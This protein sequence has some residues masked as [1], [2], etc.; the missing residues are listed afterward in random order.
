MASHNHL[1]DG[2]QMNEKRGMRNPGWLSAAITGSIFTHSHCYNC[3]D[4]YGRT[5][6]NRSCG[7]TS[8]IWRSQALAL[9][10]LCLAA[11]RDQATDAVVRTAQLGVGK[12]A[13]TAALAG[14]A[15]QANPARLPAVSLARGRHSTKCPR[16]LQSQSAIYI[17]QFFS[18]A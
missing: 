16:R 9:S 3:G 14:S 15:D 13:G 4:L 10:P 18:G 7:A 8:V 2:E 6:A 11:P 12:M 17:P 5:R 1:C